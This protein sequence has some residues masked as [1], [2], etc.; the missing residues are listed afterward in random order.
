MKADVCRNCDSQQIECL[1]CGKDF[2]NHCIC[3]LD[4]DPNEEVH[5]YC[6][7]CQTVIETR[8]SEFIQ[9]YDPLFNNMEDYDRTAYDTFLSDQ[10]EWF[11]DSGNKESDDNGK[12]IK[13]H[14]SY[15]VEDPCD[16]M[17]EKFETPNGVEIYASALL[18]KS[19]RRKPSFALYLDD[20]WPSPGFAYYI[21]WPDRSIPLETEL[22]DACL[23][24][25]DVYK[26]ARNGLFVE[27]GCL[28]GHGRTG[29]VLSCMLVL[30][31]LKPKEAIDY[32]KKHYCDRSIESLDQEWFI[33]YFRC[34]FN[35][36]ETPPFPFEE[37]SYNFKKSFDWEAWDVNNPDDNYISR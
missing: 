36:G 22:D 9:Y 31:G 16:H 3:Y 4:N 26:K 18:S 2:H 7:Y 30:E 25:A 6:H 34:F 23:V 19:P 15:I 1:E 37:W 10:E 28:G 12:I 8:V 24:I 14:M 33:Y 32:T 27:V 35:G 13:K 5:L 20:A 29:T 17:Q 21:D 11:E